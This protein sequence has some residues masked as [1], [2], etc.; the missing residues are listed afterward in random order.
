MDN[1]NV[2]QLLNKTKKTPSFPEVFI[3]LINDDCKPKTTLP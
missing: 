1:I 2:Q 3:L